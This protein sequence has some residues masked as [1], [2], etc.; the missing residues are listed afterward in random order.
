M[1]ETVLCAAEHEPAGFHPQGE[2]GMSVRFSF[3]AE[4]GADEAAAESRFDTFLRALPIRRLAAYRLE[5]VTA[6]PSSNR[7]S[8]QAVG[9]LVQVEPDDALRE[10]FAAW[11]RARAAG[12]FAT[13]AAP[14]EQEISEAGLSATHVLQGA[15]NWTAPLPHILGLTTV[16]RF[17]AADLPLDEH[18]PAC[19]VVP[20]FTDGDDFPETLEGVAVEVVGSDRFVTFDLGE[21]S[22]IV[23]RCSTNVVAW[24]PPDETSL[25]DV[26][27]GFVRNPATSRDLR[28]VI[29]A[30]EQK[31]GSLLTPLSGLAKLPWRTRAAAEGSSDGARLEVDQDNLRR[32]TWRAFAS[33]TAALDPVLIALTMP[34]PRD[35]ADARRPGRRGP[36]LGPLVD[37]FRQADAAAPLEPRLVVAAF[38]EAVRTLPPFRASF[39]SREERA[40]AIWRFNNLLAV[41]EAA[42]RVTLDLG[43]TPDVAANPATLDLALAKLTQG[44]GSSLLLPWLQ[45]YIIDPGHDR[46]MEHLKNAVFGPAS[47]NAAFWELEGRRELSLRRLLDAELAPLLD[48]T[49]SENALEGLLLRLLSSD[50]AFD[51]AVAGQ[52]AGGDP[53][54]EDRLATASAAARVDFERLLAGSFNGAEA[55]RQALSAVLLDHL[56]H[57]WRPQDDHSGDNGSAWSG[58]RLRVGTSRFW[59]RRF[60]QSGPEKAP[61]L[62][63]DTLL[64]GLVGNTVPPSSSEAQEIWTALDDGLAVAAGELFPDGYGRRFSPS[65]F[66]PAVPLQITL[67]QDTDDADAFEKAFS[68][69]AVLVRRVPS[70]SGSSTFAQANLAELFLDG[71]SAENS[72]LGPSIAPLE[73]VAVDGRRQLFLDFNGLP[74]TTAAFDDTALAGTTVASGERP[75]YRTDYPGDLPGPASVPFLAY[76]TDIE[77]AGFVVTRGGSLPLAL[78]IGDGAPPWEPKLE[79]APG[80]VP[81]EQ[82]RTRQNAATV[83][84]SER[85]LRRTA[86]GRTQIA[87]AARSGRP[88]LG[89]IPTDV[90]PLSADYRRL[91]LAGDPDGIYL[92]LF[93][94]ADGSGALALGTEIEVKLDEVW[95]WLAAANLI[96]E[97]HERG[98]AGP[99]AHPLARLMAPFDPGEHG[100][101]TLSLRRDEAGGPTRATLK[102]DSEETS[103]TLG[104]VVEAVWLRLRLEA[105]RRTPGATLSF[106]DPTASSPEA[107]RRDSAT[108]LLIAPDNEAWVPDVRKPVSA[109]LQFPRV[110]YQDLDRWLA[111]DTLPPSAPRGRERRLLRSRLLAASIARTVDEVF[112]ARLDRL[113]DPAVAG[114]LVELCPLD[115]IDAPPDVI[116]ASEG[117]WR[118]VV[119]TRLDALFGTAAAQADLG[120]MLKSLEESAHA[121]LRIVSS[122]R[123]L[124]LNRQNGAIVIGVPQGRTA[125]LT[126]MPLVPMSVFDPNGEQSAVE[127]RL[128]EWATGRFIDAQGELGSP[129]G[130]F[131]V[132]PGAALTLEGVAEGLKDADWPE[133]VGRGLRHAPEGRARAY[134]LDFD[135]D[136][137]KDQRWQWREVGSVETLT[138]GWRFMGRPIYTWFHP[139]PPS[140]GTASVAVDA[141]TPNLGA[142]ERQAFVGRTDEDGLPGAV[143]IA[144]APARSR[145]ARVVWGEPGA[146]VFRHRFRVR[147]R[148][149]GLLARAGDRTR[150]AWRDLNADE[151]AANRPASWFRVAILA[152][153]PQEALTRPQLRA[154]VPLTVATDASAPSPPVLA[155]LQEK[156][157]V[158]GGL[159]AR[160]AS[161]IHTG[162]GYAT[163]TVQG[164]HGAESRVVPHD[165]RQEEGPDPRLAYRGREAEAPP[166]VLPAEGPI[167]LTFDDPAAPA[168]AFPNTALVLQ[169]MVLDGPGQPASAVDSERL[170]GVV[171][172]RYLDPRWVIDSRPSEARLD[173]SWWYELPLSDVTNGAQAA[174]EDLRAFTVDSFEV[175]RIRRLSQARSE[176]VVEIAAAAIDPTLPTALRDSSLRLCRVP[177]AVSARLAFLHVPLQP[178]RWSVSVFLA[179]QVAQGGDGASVPAPN[180]PVLLASMDWS[181]P[182]EGQPSVTTSL[183]GAVITLPAGGELFRA[184]ASALTS[185][186]WVRTNRDFDLVYV[187]DSESAGQLPA[188]ALSAEASRDALTFRRTAEGARNGLAAEVL[189]AAWLSS[190]PFPLQVQRHLALVYSETLGELG[191]P[192]ELPRFPVRRL[193]GAETGAVPLDSDG[194]VRIVEFETPAVIVGYSPVQ[195]V[196]LPEHKRPYIDLVS[197]DSLGRSLLLS[198]RLV[199]ASSAKRAV[200]RLRLAVANGPGESRSTVL[201]FSA[202]GRS[203]D[204]FHLLL[205]MGNTELVASQFIVDQAGSVAAVGRGPLDASFSTMVGLQLE[206]ESFETLNS[207]GNPEASEGWLETSLLSLSPDK[208]REGQPGYHDDLSLLTTFDFDWVLK[209][210]EEEPEA[211]I[212][213]RAL[214]RRPEAQARI[215]SVSP[216]IPV[217]MP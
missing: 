143:P 135:P 83:V 131:A 153:R 190:Q 52:L 50:P 80:D 38:K 48:A 63:F 120:I 39:S 148:Y 24:L 84:Q 74:F 41:N 103:D 109:F 117:S 112:A 162:I 128:V 124:T 115:G 121:E 201:E 126:A 71:G 65:R 194:H 199:A 198:M 214:A 166:L 209:P 197:T 37:I 13:P 4:P 45:A 185:L 82:A 119:P 95:C 181:L 36:V 150:P 127:P 107:D 35:T 216:D 144:P 212:T 60:G 67:D 87:D 184:E 139:D 9:R 149:A 183:P 202:G 26:N 211:A 165:A 47:E 215:V 179:P 1:P 22:G 108:L 100:P 155:I 66:P 217:S 73:T 191:R 51:R 196:V 163:D 152:D 79:V 17:D 69:V 113:P 157:L 210:G 57:G 193:I 70:E 169:P 96:V 94:R 16:A 188:T 208:Q 160:V 180:Q 161:G 77:V 192:L 56:L 90:R 81:E 14:S 27:T 11:L 19:V 142:F 88:R 33:L 138:Q 75:F 116:T 130:S 55:V 92:D 158:E 151:L 122:A 137:I 6:D 7:L 154:L 72:A 111:N 25:V 12:R 110:T 204:W 132:F 23:G 106:A 123:G 178:G 68:G 125:R 2:V 18:A 62:P 58:A 34:D 145:L 53:D 207:A 104:S 49:Q 97:V 30:M 118:L 76:G 175:F 167:G 59:A 140:P 203:V 105:G 133:I 93:R 10:K 141:A 42:Q 85:Y 61:S 195:G 164:E 20:F 206:I 136:G 40:V 168:P 173:E 172:R 15:G 102:W 174:D 64:N 86:I 91:S 29:V 31:A 134:S 147:S 5:E 159:A 28:R 171:L 44:P 89:L 189:P 213:P 46:L 101:V 177:L 43:A 200:S 170:L 32:L 54:L 3:M 99:D 78:Q 146:T 176:D 8:L 129:G 182:T 187:K 98:D 186:T 156:P 205:R 21:D 114:L